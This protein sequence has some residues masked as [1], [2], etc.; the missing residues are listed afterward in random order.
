M[1][2]FC[3]GLSK[4]LNRMGARSWKNEINIKTTRIITVLNLKM[5]IN[6]I[7]Y[8]KSLTRLGPGKILL[9]FLCVF[10]LLNAYHFVLNSYKSLNKI[11]KMQSRE[12]KM[13][14]VLSQNEVMEDI[15]NRIDLS[16]FP[17]F[18]SYF[19]DFQFLKQIESVIKI[20]QK[21]NL[22]ILTLVEV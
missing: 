4:L 21:E 7:N 3:F 9:L 1:G 2:N 14:L 19:S 13:C 16:N 22:Y 11:R 17:K 6:E 10:R 15:M 20:L 12:I 18:N 5:E 8:Q